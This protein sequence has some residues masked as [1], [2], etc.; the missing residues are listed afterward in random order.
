MAW[1]AGSLAQSRNCVSMAAHISVVSAFNALGRLSVMRP[2]APARRNKT[3]A[4][5]M[6]ALYAKAS[7]IEGVD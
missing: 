1:T 5:A 3:S 6:T 7:E 2:I 4:L